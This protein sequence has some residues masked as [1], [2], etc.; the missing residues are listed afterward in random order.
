MKEIPF[1]SLKDVT[2]LHGQEIREAIE[3]VVVSGWYLQG[4]ANRNFECNYAK[5]IGTNHAV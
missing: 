4:E 2:A 5:F 1:L 3:K